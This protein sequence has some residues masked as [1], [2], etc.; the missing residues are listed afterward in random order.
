MMN[1]FKSNLIVI[2]LFYVATPIAHIFLDFDGIYLMLVITV[3]A[4]TVIFHELGHCFIG[5][6]R[7]MEI[8]FISGLPG[9]F[10][11]GR[12][13]FKIPMY[14]SF[15]AMLAYKPLKKGRITKSDIIWLN[16]GGALFNLLVIIILLPIK[17]IFD[18]ENSVL[19]FAILANLI[20]GIVTGLNPVAADGKSIWNLIRGKT[21]ELKFYDSM[22]Y[23]YDPEVDSTR[24]LSDINE[25]R[26]I[27]ANY[28]CNI[29]WIENQVEN[30]NI[31]EI[32]K[33]ELHD[34]EELNRKLARAFQTL[35]KA[36]DGNQI[37]AEE[38][39]IFKE[40]NTSVYFVFGDIYKYFKTG[41]DE[42][43]RKLRKHKSWL[44]SQREDMLLLKAIQKL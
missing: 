19:N 29:A 11:N 33:V 27:I 10:M 5:K 36:A 2:V 30:N 7:G 40:V 44:P 26:D 4:L 12:W 28:S 8:S 16:L 9:M 32:Y 24:I 43:L 38:M 15:G 20:I 41:N 3:W 34:T 14:F 1:F 42:I 17:Y 35:Y 21:D 39:E 37:T 23:M 22:N 31:S 6:C 18:I 13:Y 25:N